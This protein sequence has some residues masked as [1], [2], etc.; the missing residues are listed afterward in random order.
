MYNWS[1]LSFLLFKGFLWPKMIQ[2]LRVMIFTCFLKKTLL[3]RKQF[4]CW[5]QR[6]NPRWRRYIKSLSL[7]LENFTLDDSQNDKKKKKWRED[8]NFKYIFLLEYFMVKF[9]SSVKHY[10]WNC[11]HYDILTDRKTK[12]IPTLIRL[13]FMMKAMR[14]QC[15][16]YITM[17]E[18]KDYTSISLSHI[19]ML[20]LCAILFKKGIEY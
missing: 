20:T 11:F 5:F 18:L 9:F 4:Y 7:Q 12:S 16:C 19:F 17:T 1:T 2:A 6:N 15:K 14:L 13:T 10:Q 3:N 8:H